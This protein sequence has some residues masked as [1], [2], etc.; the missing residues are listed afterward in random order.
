ML[1]LSEIGKAGMII[2]YEDIISMIGFNV[3]RYLHS[4]GVS[5]K[6]DSMSIKDVL[7][8]YI[9]REELDYSVWLKKE[10]D[11]DINPNDY[12]DSF[13]T[14]QPNLLYSYKVFGSAHKEKIDS[15][16][17]YSDNYYSIAE[18]AVDSYGFKG[19]KY[20]HN[21]LGEF[22]NEHPN[23]TFLTSSIDN[24]KLCSELTVPMVLLICD[25]YL[26]TSEIF[27]S[28]LDKKLKEKPNIILRFTG[29]IS[30]GV[31]N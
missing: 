21:N 1:D 27:S 7:L 9:N 28:K 13:L 12:T 5:K 24:I 25:D 23:Y 15:L 2:Q 10:F 22:L 16:Y 8:S 3:A 17:I 20:I 31:I 29:V 30:A 11:V 4:K 18:Q 14:M 19:V 26:Y 6:L